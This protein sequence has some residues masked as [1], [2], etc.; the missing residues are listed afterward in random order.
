MEHY[1]LEKWADFVRQV[2]GERERAEMQSHLDNE[3]C[4]KC[5][6]VLGLWQRVH[7]AA[8][9]ELSYQ[10][11]ESA[12]RSMK[13]T[14]A[15]Q[16]PRKAIPGARSIA[17]LLFD[18]AVSPLAVGVRSAATTSRQLLYG[19]GNYRID[20]R[21][22]IQADSQKIAVVGQVLNSADPDE[23]VGAVPVT[24]VRGHKV[25]AE[26]VTSPFG[27]FDVECDRKG[28]F[29]LRVMLP[30]EVLTLPLI[31]PTLGG[32]DDVPEIAHSKSLTWDRSKRNKRTRKKV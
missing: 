10:P 23:I 11:P 28:P 31:E 7:V 9:R 3:D 27:E 4:R 15:I 5:S 14:F 12:V 21:I 16:G 18:S 24:L 26:T 19:A 6:K 22:E 30:S 32:V 2:I 20:V 29:E 13:G 8:R 17:E 25:L 1:S